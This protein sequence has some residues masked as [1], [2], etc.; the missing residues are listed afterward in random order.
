MVIAGTRP[1]FIK[2]APLLKLLNRDKDFALIFALSGQ[3]YDY[4][5]NRK[6]L[7]DL[8]I[9]KPDFN[10][11]VQS[12]THGYQTGT[13]LMKIEDLIKKVD[14]DLILSQG[15]TNTVLSSALASIKSH[16]C[17]IHLEAGIRSFDKRMP[18]EI[19][20]ILT[21]HCSKYHLA[22]TRRAAINL[23]FE[24]IS[25]DSI[26]IVGNTIVDS[27]LKIKDLAKLKSKIFE[28]LNL[29]TTDPLILITL[30]RPSN[31]DSKANLTEFVEEII[32]LKQYSF[33]FPIHPRT[34]KKLKE[35]NLLQK[36]K[37]SWNIKITKPLGYLDFI[38]IFSQSLCVITDSGGI[39]EEA[40]ILKVPCV[41]LR[42]NTERPETLEYG[43]NVLVGRNMNKMVDEINRIKSDPNYL[44]PKS[45]E[46][47]FGD[48]NSSER[49]IQILK[50]LYEENKIGISHS[51]LWKKIPRRELRQI[52][53]KDIGLTVEKYENK[54]N[55]KVYSIF[56]KDG[57][58]IVPQKNKLLK[59]NQYV[60]AY[61]Y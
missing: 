58:P 37:E 54:H 33:I 4:E 17:F 15:D 14:P 12:G 52:T 47:P 46:N 18:E 53:G 7:D 44:K 27:I 41:T 49:I 28:D 16:K 29:S 20:R 60:L 59:R 31:V 38:K 24:G 25:P 3:H 57:I 43:S 5:M 42:N 51:K 39:Q 34:E 30:H 1:E 2:L 22:P 6:I 32:E 11:N 50:E 40:S 23:I 21:G 13:L 48:G 56:N 26:F 19:N 45:E 36:L 61:L 8:D 9:V 35:F 10:I 55:L